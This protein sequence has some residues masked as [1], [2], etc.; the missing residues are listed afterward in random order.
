MK[1][2]RDTPYYVTENGEVYRLWKKG[3]KKLKSMLNDGYYYVDIHSKCYRIHR[4]VA[5]CYIPNPNN[6][7]EVDHIDTDKS[8][9]HFSNLEWVTTQENIRRAKQNNLFPKGI[10]HSQA[11]L[12][13]IDIIWM[14]K[15]YIPRHPEFGTRGLGRK[16]NINSSHISKILRNIKWSHINPEQSSEYE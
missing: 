11:K 10:N 13:E 6:L 1:Q 9:N 14:K 7:P 16:F 12:T 3:F 4:L 15:H 5:E 8:N 2:F